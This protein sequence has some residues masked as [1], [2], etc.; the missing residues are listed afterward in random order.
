MLLYS[1]LTGR[2]NT[3]LA[4]LAITLETT[5]SWTDSS[6]SP[7]IQCC[8]QNS[9]ELEPCLM[10][11]NYWYDKYIYARIIFQL[12]HPTS[13]HSPNIGQVES[14]P[15]E[16]GLALVAR[17][18]M[19]WFSDHQLSQLF[20]MISIDISS[21]IKSQIYINLHMVPNLHIWN[22]E[23]VKSNL[24]TIFQISF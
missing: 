1:L 19:T 8:H 10:W 13:S 20:L 6:E 12:H 9:S 14:G 11:I 15:Q 4:K 18:A 17:M 23:S 22:P 21:Q 16:T 3:I 7:W 5:G 24:K 2:S